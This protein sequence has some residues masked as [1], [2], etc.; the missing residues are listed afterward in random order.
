[1]TKS[2]ENVG[3]FVSRLRTHCTL[4]FRI[5]AKDSN[6]DEE[7]ARQILTVINMEKKKLCEKRAPKLEW[8]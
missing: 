4:Y 2:D 6:M 8:R 3:K 7:T 5:I 1:M